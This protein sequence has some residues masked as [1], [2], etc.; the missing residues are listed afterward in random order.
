L[1]RESPHKSRETPGERP[2]Q[3]VTLGLTRDAQEGELAEE[4]NFSNNGTPVKRF[5]GY[6][7]LSNRRLIPQITRETR[8]N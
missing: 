6:V 3:K 1:R 8:E 7:L 2:S 5:G 4:M